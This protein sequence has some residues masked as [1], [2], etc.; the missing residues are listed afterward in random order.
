[1]TITTE[2]QINDTGAA[3]KRIHGKIGGVA[4]EGG[5]AFFRMPTAE[6]FDEFAAVPSEEQDLRRRAFRRYVREAFVCALVN[7][8]ELGPECFDQIAATE[9]PAWVAGPAGTAV[10]K[11]AGAKERAPARFF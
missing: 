10:N 2:Q 7:G 1:M 5:C 3:L 9:G 4:I 6:A 11:L 8:A